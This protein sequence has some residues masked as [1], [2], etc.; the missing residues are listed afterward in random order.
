[1]IFITISFLAIAALGTPNEAENARLLQTNRALRQALQE[2]QVGVDEEQVGNGDSSANAPNCGAMTE[3]KACTGSGFKMTDWSRKLLGSTQV[4]L[5]GGVNTRVFCQQQCHNFGVPGCCEYQGDHDLCV[6]YP[7]TMSTRDDPS[8]DSF[9]SRSSRKMITIPNRYAA[10]CNI[11][12]CEY[13]MV[14]INGPKETDWTQLNNNGVCDFARE[15]KFGYKRGQMA[16]QKACDD[17]CLADPKCM[18]AAYRS[19]DCRRFYTCNQV[20]KD[21]GGSWDM[22]QKI[23]KGHE[24]EKDVPLPG[25]GGHGRL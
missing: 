17:A 20:F 7:N 1:M 8:E 22:N 3:Y 19:G 6:F 10:I 16:S 13:H 9:W 14:K 23:C 4:T 18:V 11:P 12:D 5:Y 21:S 2:L 25:R 24:E 15:D